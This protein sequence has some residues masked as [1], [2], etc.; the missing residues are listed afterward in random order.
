MIGF[1]NLVDG[2]LT[3]T[4]RIELD[5]DGE[6]TVVEELSARAPRPAAAER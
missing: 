5:I 6:L 3:R 2:K 1:Y 4:D